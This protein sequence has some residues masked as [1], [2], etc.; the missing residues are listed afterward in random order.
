[1]SVSV[2]RPTPHLDVRATHLSQIPEIRTPPSPRSPEPIPGSSCYALRA[3][4]ANLTFWDDYD[5]DFIGEGFFS[6][7]YKVRHKTSGDVLVVKLSKTLQRRDQQKVLQE[8][9]LLNKLQHRN[10]VG[11]RGACVKDGHIHPLL[12][13]VSGGCLEDLLANQQ[14]SLSW[15][16]KIQLAADVS[17]GMSYLHSRNICHRDLKSANCLIRHLENGNLEAVVTDFG[18]ARILMMDNTPLSPVIRK[19]YPVLTLDDPSN[20]GQN[21]TKKPE[22]PRKMSLVGSAFWMAPE[23]LRG[24]EYTRQVDVFSF[25]IILCEIIARVVADPEVLPRTKSFGL[26][27][28]AFRQLAGDCPEPLILLADQCCAMDSERR[29]PFSEIETRLQEMLE[30]LTNQ[31]FSSANH[32]AKTSQELQIETEGNAKMTEEN[33]S[34]Q[35]TVDEKVAENRLTDQKDN[36]TTENI[37]DTD[38]HVNNLQNCKIYDNKRK[39][40]KRRNGHYKIE[41]ELEGR[42]LRPKESPTSI[43]SEQN[44]TENVLDED[45]KVKGHDSKQF[46]KSKTEVIVCMLC[47]VLII[48]LQFCGVLTACF[49]AILIGMGVILLKNVESIGDFTPDSAKYET[50]KSGK[51]TATEKVKDEDD[52][53]SNRMQD[54]NGLEEHSSTVVKN[55]P[56]LRIISQ[57]NHNLTS[58][59]T[60]RKLYKRSSLIQSAALSIDESIE[61]ED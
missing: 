47:L 25:G 31:T 53:N 5:A 37:L 9:E 24:E 18:L 45:E 8:L 20:D 61:E 35:K 21:P 39:N 13:Y 32:S 17:R 16:Q 30:N 14:I 27:V 19:R 59:R 38:S 28:E 49:L 55:D 34:F 57:G 40:L 4:V 58:Q 56:T 26:D 3:A 22:L 50:G 52:H 36:V 41:G 15:Q 42:T 54:N 11:Y 29:P 6:K 12:E 10:I 23:M 33:H 46:P 7:V 51:I 48:S 43:Q 60:K 2:S 44:R 1:M